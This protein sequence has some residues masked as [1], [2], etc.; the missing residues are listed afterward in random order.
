VSHYFH[1]PRVHDLGDDAEAGLAAHLG[2]DL[3][4]FHS[5]SLEGVGVG[6][7]FEHPAAHQLASGLTHQAGGAQ[8][9]LHRFDGAGSGDDH[10]LRSA[11]QGLA[12]RKSMGGRRVLVLG[13]TSSEDAEVG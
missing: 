6:A 12:N 8:G 7:R 1:H 2:E 4:S 11:H 3:Q 13:P 5:Q 10:R 9:L